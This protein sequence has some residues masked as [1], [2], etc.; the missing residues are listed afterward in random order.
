MT[1][2]FVF[3]HLLLWSPG[4]GNYQRAVDL[5]KQGH[6]PQVI[7]NLDQL[8]SEEALRPAAQNL[9]SVALMNMGQFEPALLASEAAIRQDPDNPNY[10]YN[11]GLILLTAKRLQDAERAFR[12]GVQRFPKS[13]QLYEG[14]GDTLFKLNRFDESEQALKVAAQAGPGSAS[15]LASLAKLYYS[16]G[17]QER[18]AATVKMAIQADSSN[19]VACYLFGK[20]LI[21][22]AGSVA[23]GRTYVARSIELAPR[24]EDALIEWGGLMAGEGRWKEAAEA[25]ERAAQSNPAR[26]QTYYLMYA[27]Y[28]KSGNHEKAEWALGEYRRLTG[29]K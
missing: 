29:A 11:R 8:P 25:Y 6:F 27:A 4:G 12:E 2:V 23:E 20:Y 24:F 22:Q 9:R 18:F 26:S 19:Y 7:Q 14:L 1:S 17:D 3:L 10:A 16:L 5:F 13:R 21:E 28:R 15:A